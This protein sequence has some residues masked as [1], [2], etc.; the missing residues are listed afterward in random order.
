[1]RAAET[2]VRK[3]YAHAHPKPVERLERYWERMVI[4]YNFPAAHWKHIRTTN[5][6]ESPFAAVR[7]RTGAAKLLKKM[8]NATE[9]ATRRTGELPESDKISDSF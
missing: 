9:G 2:R 6:I 7:L 4:F 3:V 1:M 5:I 8:E